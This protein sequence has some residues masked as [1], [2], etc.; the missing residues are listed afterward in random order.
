M[1]KERAFNEAETALN[2]LCN[3]KFMAKKD[4]EADG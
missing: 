4:G 1:D 2:R 3:F